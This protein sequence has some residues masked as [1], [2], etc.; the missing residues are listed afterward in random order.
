MRE[1]IGSEGSV[2]SVWDSFMHKYGCGTGVLPVSSSE[3]Q[4]VMFV[5][6]EDGHRLVGCC[7][8]ELMPLTSTGKPWWRGEVSSHAQKLEHTRLVR[9]C[10]FTP[11]FP[12]QISLPPPI[13]SVTNSLF[14]CQPKK[15]RNKASILCF[16]D[17]ICSRLHECGMRRAKLVCIFGAYL[18]YP[19]EPPFFFFFNL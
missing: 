5:A 6:E 13:L 14:C 17:F 3:R 7:G 16:L 1:M 11:I 19:Q 4:S 9:C 12:L 2:E 8:M 10:D 18:S 15:Y